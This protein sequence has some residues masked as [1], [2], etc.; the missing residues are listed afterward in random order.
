M[1]PDL[2]LYNNSNENNLHCIA[3]KS[4]NF[5]N[6]KT[7]MSIFKFQKSIQLLNFFALKE[8][9]T[10]N[11]M[12]ALKLM[13]AAERLHLRTHGMTIINDDFFAMK[14]GPV[15]SF[16]KDMAEGGNSL[17]D[18]ESAYRS[19]YLITISDYSFGSG[20]GFDDAH[21]S[22]NAITS[23]EK[24]FE[25]FGKYDGFELADITHL[26]P[27]WSKFSQLI[28][29]VMSRAD[30]NYLDFF[31]DP[32]DLYFK[33]FNQDQEDLVY[34]KNLFIEQSQ[35]NDAVYSL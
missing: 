17:S 25:E 20:K 12:K 2:T 1:K 4:S 32:K 28:P 6:S 13:W 18:E 34:L 5:V 3:K 9:G 26:Y 10:I 23:L 31:S 19:E 21:F 16:T 27:E 29:K 30:M 8:G 35:F 11:K 7:K 22:N 14:Y 15:P 24:V 33:I